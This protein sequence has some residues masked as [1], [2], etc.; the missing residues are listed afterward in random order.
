MTTCGINQCL[1]GLHRR[2]PENSWIGPP[3]FVGGFPL[4]PGPPVTGP[5]GFVLAVPRV[6]VYSR[7][8]STAELRAVLDVERNRDLNSF[9]L[10][11]PAGLEP[12]EC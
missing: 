9:L 8:L 4:N 12:Y 11:S 5:G 10:S 3:G 1:V 2:L 7:A 6:A